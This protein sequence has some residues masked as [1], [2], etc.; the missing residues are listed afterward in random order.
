MKNGPKGPFFIALELGSVGRPR[1][2]AGKGG[3]LQYIHCTIIIL[4]DF[5]R[6]QA[7]SRA[8]QNVVCRSGSSCR[9]LM[10][11]VSIFP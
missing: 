9:R 4:N 1:L 10:R 3:E 11:T 7:M 5:G 8:S 2:D 6:D